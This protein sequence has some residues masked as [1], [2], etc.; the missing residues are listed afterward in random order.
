MP[1]QPSPIAGA[2]TVAYGP[3]Q[4]LAVY[5]ARGKVNSPSMSPSPAASGPIPAP[6]P[7]AKRLLSN[8]TKRNDDNAAPV[9]QSGEMRSFV[10]LHNGTASSAAVEALPAPGPQAQAGNGLMPPTMTRA[11]S[12]SVARQSGASQASDYS[13]DHVGSAQ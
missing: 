7:T 9:P 4:M 6:R 5:A 1:A 3:D 8:L 12:N 11:R 2:Q 10:H 13:D